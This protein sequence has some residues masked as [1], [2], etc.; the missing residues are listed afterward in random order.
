[1]HTA[2]VKTKFSILEKTGIIHIQY[3]LSFTVILS[4]ATCKVEDKIAQEAVA[5]IIEVTSYTNKTM[6]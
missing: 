1:M 2:K 3:L 6:P 4:L 5:P